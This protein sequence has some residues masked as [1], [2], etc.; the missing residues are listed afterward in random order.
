MKELE[1]ELDAKTNSPVKKSLFSIHDQKK[2]NSNMENKEN[3]S[4]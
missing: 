1:H 2:R 3:I 4:N